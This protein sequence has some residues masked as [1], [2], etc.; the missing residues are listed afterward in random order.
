MKLKDLFFSQVKKKKKDEAGVIF[1]FK[2]L[3]K[4]NT[5]PAAALAGIHCLA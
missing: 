4:V 1:I 3:K 5:P 2:N